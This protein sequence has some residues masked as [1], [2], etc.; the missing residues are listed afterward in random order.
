MRWKAF[1]KYSYS[2]TAYLSVVL[3]TLGVPTSGFF[4]RL[5]IRCRQRW[6]W[7]TAIIR[8]SFRFSPNIRTA[9]FAGGGVLKPSLILLCISHWMNVAISGMQ[10]EAWDPL[11]MEFSSA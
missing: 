1:P 11:E 4:N 9:S 8:E 3:L 6:S 5:N 10:A 2:S 7:G